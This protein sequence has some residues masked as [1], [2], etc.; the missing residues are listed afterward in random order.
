MLLM[1]R[2]ET[3]RPRRLGTLF[4]LASM[5][6]T[7]ASC[8]GT[9]RS[10]VTFH[11]PNMDFSQ[12]ERVAVLPF[13]NLTPTQAAGERVRDV[14]MTMLQATGTF[15]VVPP[16][17]VTRGV[18]RSRVQNA[19]QP[20]AEDLIALGKEIKVQVIFTGTVRE[21]GEVRSGNTPANAVSVSL[22]MLETQ[23]GQ[24]VWSA[25]STKGGVSAGDRLLGGKG[26]PMNEVTEQAVRDLLDSLFD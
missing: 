3:K 5:A 1:D 11:N 18:T 10:E 9:K 17:E 20:T 25:S 12:I 21:Y 14:F 16:G 2:R 6:L 26:L 22:Q 24:L 19:A 23:T 15:Y 7:L 4:A 8:A 13:T